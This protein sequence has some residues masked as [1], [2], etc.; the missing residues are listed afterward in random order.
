MNRVRRNVFFE[1]EHARRLDE[2]ST[3]KNVSKSS[4][5]AAALAAFLSPDSADKREGGII[6]RLDKLTRQ[7]DCLDRDQTILIETLALFIR[8]QLGLAAQIPE[9]H[10]PL[11]RAQGRARFGSFIEQLVQHLQ[12]GGSLVKQVSEEIAPD[13]AQRPQGAQ[14]TEERSAP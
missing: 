14:V 12:R 8:H 5:V 2:L 6:R 13:R 9:A 1:R 4:I 10:Q 7:F 11:V 3:M